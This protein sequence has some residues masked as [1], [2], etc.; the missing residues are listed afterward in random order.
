MYNKG[1]KWPLSLWKQIV[2]RWI[3]KSVN[4]N[5]THLFVQIRI[6]RNEQDR[7]GCLL[8]V[9][10]AVLQIV[11]LRPTKQDAPLSPPL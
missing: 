3:A 2:T 10:R 1:S 4:I 8:S 11:S 6:L 7:K 9:R 5:A